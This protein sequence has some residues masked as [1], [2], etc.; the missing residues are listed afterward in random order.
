GG[1]R[2]SIRWAAE[3]RDAHARAD[4]A[5]SG[6]VQGGLTLA[7]RRE[8]AE[9]LAKLDFPGY[10]LGGFSVGES[11]DAMHAALPA[12]AGF[13]PPNKPRYLMGVGRPE[14]ILIAV[15]AGGGKFECVV[16]PRNGRDAPPPPPHAP[17]R[18]RP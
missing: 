10:A 11:P 14:D 4:Q 5:M 3:C 17:P 2:R 6:I 9:A 18:L 13:L 1:V 7:L 12:C 15:A 8:C 16:A